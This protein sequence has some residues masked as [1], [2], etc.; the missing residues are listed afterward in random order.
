[1]ELL[2]AL[3]S[4]HRAAVTAHLLA[5]GPR[6]RADRFTV[7]ADDA[8]VKRYADGIGY[9]RDILLGVL[10]GRKLVGVAHAAVHVE[11]GELVTEVGV[12]VDADARKLGIGRQL[13]LGAMDAA[14]RFEVC[15]VDVLF[16]S[17]NRAMAALTRSIGGRVERDGADSAAVFETG[18]GRGLPLTVHHGRQ[19]SEVL[20]AIHPHERGRALLV[21][22]AG[23]DSYQWLPHLLPELWKAGFSVCA[24]TLPGHGRGGDP[25]A[26]RLD[27]LLACV[28]ET[29]EAFGPTLIVGHSMGGYLVQRHLEA[30]PAMRAVLLASLPPDVPAADDLAHLKAEL[31]CADS[32]TVLDTA[33]A[34]AP[35]VDV[36]AAGRTP[37]VV[38]GGTRDRVVPM[39]WVRHTARRYR[40]EPRFVEGGHRLMMG[41]AA[42]AVVAALPARR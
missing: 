29:A 37:L 31:H 30:H 23:G 26:A 18:A 34:G 24:P 1:M 33:I 40:V 38:L 8:Y 20:Q 7:A 3:D 6:D 28:S 15:R 19:G 9:A 21:H 4:R 11:R 39:P 16:R 13:L 14:R 2:I 12:S 10:R 36:Q 35:E 27:D 5:L 41:R 17:G 22:G 25:A 42:S 32:R